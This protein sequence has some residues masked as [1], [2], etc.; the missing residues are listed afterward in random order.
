MHKKRNW[1]SGM[2]L[3]AALVFMAVGAIYYAGHDPFGGAPAVF[4]ADGHS[5]HG[6]EEVVVGAAAF[7][8]FDRLVERGNRRLRFPRPKLSHAERIPGHGQ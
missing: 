1:V 6:E 2:I 8:E 5:G 4:A 3:A 7:A